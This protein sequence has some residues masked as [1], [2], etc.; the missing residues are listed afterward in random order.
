M[1]ASVVQFLRSPGTVPPEFQDYFDSGRYFVTSANNVI[2]WWKVWGAV[3]VS[4]CGCLVYLLIILAHFDT[5]CLPNLWVRVFRDGSL[6]ERNLLLLL[7]VFWIAGLNINTGSLSAGEW[8][9]N[10]FFTTWIA[11]CATVNNF[12][13]WRESAGLRSWFDREAHAREST[14]NW[15]WTA[16]FSLVLAGSVSDVYYYRD[17]ITL[18]S[19]GQKLNISQTTWI[20]IL[21]LA[22]AFFGICCVAILLNCVQVEPY[23]LPCHCR[24][25]EQPVRCVLGWRHLEGLVL[26]LAVGVTFYVVLVY[27]GVDT[28]VNGLSN[29]YI[30]MWGT[31]FS[32][33]STFG[34]WL[35]EN[36]NITYFIPDLEDDEPSQE[37]PT[38]RQRKPE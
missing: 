7:I 3:A 22:W 26:I 30:G 15:L 25:H 28:V 12:A 20:I 36:R 35:K 17:E 6:A 29:A 31:F 23:T 33:V 8:Q 38:G 19:N 18:Q 37:E 1:L 5:V 16:F 21:S 24:R 9:P 2:L 13:V 4:A 34:T 14:Y 10:V 11:F 27:T 32:S